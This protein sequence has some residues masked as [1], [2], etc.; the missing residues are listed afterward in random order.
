MIV[1]LRGDKIQSGLN[2]INVILV[3]KAVMFRYFCEF[4]VNIETNWKD[5][6]G[7]R[8][9]GEVGI[10]CQLFELNSKLMGTSGK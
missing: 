5:K 3:H 4:L 10:V 1:T 6:E 8:A 9:F 7:K 2:R